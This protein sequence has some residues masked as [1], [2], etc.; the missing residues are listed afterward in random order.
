[1]RLDPIKELVLA[2][3]QTFKSIH[4]LKSMQAEVEAAV[5]SRQTF[6]ELRTNRDLQV[7]SRHPTTVR[8]H[9]TSTTQWKSGQFSSLWFTDTFLK[10]VYTREE[11]EMYCRESC[12]LHA[13]A[14][15]KVIDN[16][17]PTFWGR[18]PTIRTSRNKSVRMAPLMEEIS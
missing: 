3:R 16:S 11:C 5:V 15:A 13:P 7:S 12:T 4:K 1:M 2:W 18:P 6:T 8:I 14:A 17:I 10:L 9:R